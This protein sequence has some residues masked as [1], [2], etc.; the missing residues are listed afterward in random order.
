MTLFIFSLLQKFQNFMVWNDEL[1]QY[2]V[3][4]SINS[5]KEVS[6]DNDKQMVHSG[7]YTSQN[8]LLKTC[9]VSLKHFEESF[10]VTKTLPTMKNVG[11]DFSLEPH[12][13]LHFPS[14]HLQ[15]VS[16]VAHFSI[17]Y[18]HFLN[19]SEWMTPWLTN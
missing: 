7:K 5:L 10:T 4:I 16:W 17:F 3:Q 9:S 15:D 11:I 8:A 6:K 2:T 13:V 12:T 19:L 14:N 18:L 1:D